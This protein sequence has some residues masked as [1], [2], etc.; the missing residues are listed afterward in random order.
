MYINKQ[1]PVET[2]ARIGNDAAAAGIEFKNT[3]MT[4]KYPA[5]AVIDSALFTTN[6][7][8]Q[9]LIKVLIRQTRRPELGD[10]FS[11]RH[12]RVRARVCLHFQNCRD[13]REFAGL[14]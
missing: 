3:P 12:V 11:S 5:P 10:K 7:E 6:H 13:K 8:D 2:S 9:T 1:T 4:F 14:S